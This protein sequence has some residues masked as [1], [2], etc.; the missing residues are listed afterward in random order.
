MIEF[1][2]DLKKK[3]TKILD[4]GFELLVDAEGYV[5]Q[6]QLVQK[7][8]RSQFKSENY[9]FDL[10]RVTGITPF[11][12]K[13]YEELVKT[14]PGETVSYLELGRKAGYKNASR[15]VGSAMAKNK[16]VLFVPCHRVIKSDGGLGNFS[17]CGGS[18]TKQ[19][20]LELEAQKG[21]LY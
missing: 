19:R 20:L 21:A 16:L 3:N 18:A 10:N 8:G 12:K 7:Q 5:Q 15:A 4:L 9:K 13:V 6:S 1:K 11:Q 2:S 14:S 17:G